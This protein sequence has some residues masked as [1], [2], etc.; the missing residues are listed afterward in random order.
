MVDSA[1]RQLYEIDGETLRLNFHDGQLE[2][3]DS[4]ARIVAID[5]QLAGWQNVVRS[6]VA[7]PRNRAH[8]RRR[9]HRRDR[10]ASYDLFKLKMLPEIRNVFEHILRIGRYWSGDK[11]LEIRDPVT[12][13]FLAS[14]ADDPMW[15]RIVLRSA[16]AK[17]GLESS[18]ARSAWLDEAG[19][20]ALD[21]FQAVRRRLTLYRGRI[22][23]STT[24]Y[25]LGWL[26]T[27]C[28]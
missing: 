11:V 9:P 5:R 13:K 25:D 8:R 16:E 24:P 17:G 3:W 19:L 1:R 10:T 15:G 21:A 23:I 14:R 2:A 27:D 26:K 6:V 12:G 7:E 22:L 18:T 20:F 4:L 28:R